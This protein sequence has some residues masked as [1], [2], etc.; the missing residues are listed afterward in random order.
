MII[1]TSKFSQAEER[2][3]LDCVAVVF[4]EVNNRGRGKA[5][6]LFMEK[7]ELDH[8]DC[9]RFLFGHWKD[10]ENKKASLWSS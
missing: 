4:K 7:N 9:R 10:N 6:D 2:W 5:F 3:G 1:D 8:V